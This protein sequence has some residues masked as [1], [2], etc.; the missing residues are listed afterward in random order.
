MTIYMIKLKRIVGLIGEDNMN[1]KYMIIIIV[2]FLLLSVGYAT[3]NST[4]L[5][6]DG[7]AFAKLYEGIFISK[8]NVI[9]DENDI[10]DDNSTAIIKNVDRN[11]LTSTITLPN[12]NPNAFITYEITVS[13]NTDKSYMFDEVQ[14]LLENEFYDNP[15]IAFDIEQIEKYDKLLSKSSVTFNIKFYYKDNI[16]PESNT[17]NS[18]LNFSFKE[19]YKITYENITNNN[20]PTEIMHGDNS[21]IVFT[22]D[23]PEGV[24][25]SGVESYSYENATLTITNAIKDVVISN[26][27]VFRHD[28][29][30]VFTGTNYIDTGVYLYNE[31]NIN[32]NFEVTFSIVDKAETQE[33]KAT[34]FNSLDEVNP[35]FPGILFRVTQNLLNYEVV[36]NNKING[37]N[38]VINL[39]QFSDVTK[40][41][42][43]RIDG[44]T[45]YCLNDG[46][47]YELQEYTIFNEFFEIPATFGAS[48]DSNGE[49]WRFFVGTLKDMKIKF[50]EDDYQL[51]SSYSLDYNLVAKQT[52]D[53]TNYINTGVNL[54]SEENI[55]KDFEILFTIASYESTQGTYATIMN[56]VNE[57]SKDYPGII[58]RISTSSADVESKEDFTPVKYQLVGN[59]TTRL[60][61]NTE[62]MT[63]KT[64]KLVRKSNII[65]YSI[66]YSELAQLQDFTDFTSTFDV[67]VTFGASLDAEQKPYRYFKGSLSNM[68]VRIKH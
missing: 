24:F 54:F 35:D 60:N 45:Y 61:V 56:S 49:T 11:I 43:L 58:F 18:D 48:L 57:A 25:V 12:D 30:Y 50:L 26:A 44:I 36:G 52:F 7:E 1:K 13:N 5:K 23:I 42:L 67:P 64:I 41:K 34:L 28:G 6:I 62:D 3:V 8:C 20:Y 66:N 9:Y 38:Q 27:V 22:N 10:N 40:V 19:Y 2:G 15:N 55:N 68:Q 17:L 4:T 14:Y 37:Y 46:D 63:P 31:E 59:S 29:E 21:T 53:G 33:E 47:C 16:I 51:E 65:Y 32:R 39:Y